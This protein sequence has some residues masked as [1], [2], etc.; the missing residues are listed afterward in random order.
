MCRL[1][2]RVVFVTTNY[3]KRHGR[4]QCVTVESRVPTRNSLRNNDLGRLIYCFHTL[5][6][7]HLGDRHVDFSPRHPCSVVRETGVLT[8]AHERDRKY[9]VCDQTNVN[10]N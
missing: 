4:A 3:A 2:P 1:R 6:E 9:A 10:T 5:F 8:G 7:L